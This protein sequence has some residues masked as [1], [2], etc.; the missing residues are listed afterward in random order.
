MSKPVVAVTI[1][2]SHYPRMF[3]SAAWESLDGF[4]TVVHHEDDEPADH[5]ALVELLS[6]VRACITSWGVAQLDAE[7]VAAATELE[8]VAH[9]GSSVKR[10]LSDEI[11]ERGIRVTSAGVS[12]AR[13][14][15]ETTL[16][17]MIVARKRI[18]PLGRHVSAGGWRDGPVWDRW[19]AR[20]LTRSQVGIVGASNVGRRVIE[21]LEPFETEILLF[22]PYVDDTEADTLGVRTVELDELVESAD[23]VSLHCPANAETHHLMNA[24]RLAAMRDGTAL[25]NTARGALIDEDALV[26]EL[27]SGRLFAFLDVTDPEPPAIDSPL[28]RLDN[29]VVTPHIA[30][31]IENC[32]RMGELA[33]EELRRH[34]AGEPAVYEITRDMLDRIA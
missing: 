6:G 24:D 11:W 13:D 30:G 15:A 16:G 28:R 33:V 2:R 9:M 14:V 17:L 12:L 25:I 10:F 27:E 23:V 19:D 21:L 18:W 20:E 31:C 7:V 4:A 1:G 34:F 32:T 8:A 29:V 22:D 3:S 26:A 5:D